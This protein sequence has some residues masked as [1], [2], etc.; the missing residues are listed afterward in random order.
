MITAGAYS[1]RKCPCCFC[2]ATLFFLMV[3]VC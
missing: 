3:S 2:I 1:V